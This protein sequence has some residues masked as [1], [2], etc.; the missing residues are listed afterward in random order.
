MPIKFKDKDNM[1]FIINKWW[2]MIETLDYQIIFINIDSIL[3]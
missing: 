1:N 3:I 2:Q